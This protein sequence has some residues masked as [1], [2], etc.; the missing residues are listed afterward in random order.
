MVIKMKILRA[1]Q[2]FLIILLVQSIVSS[3]AVDSSY[4]C[5]DE[6]CME[7]TEIKFSVNIFNNI[8]KTIIVKD[9]YI[10][11]K[12]YGTVLAYDVS[13]DVFLKPNEAHQ[14]NF[15][16]LVKAPTKGYTFYYVPCFTVSHEE[17]PEEESE[18]CG[19]IVKSITVIPLDKIECRSDDECADDEYCNTFSLYRCEKLECGEDETIVN[20]KCV[21]VMPQQITVINWWNVFVFFLALIVAIFFMFFLFGRKEQKDEIDEDFDIDLSDE[22]NKDSA[23]EEKKEENRKQESKKTEKKNKAEKEFKEENKEE[24]N[25]DENKEKMPKKKNKTKKKYK[26]VK[27]NIKP[28]IDENAYNSVDEKSE[29]L[30]KHNPGEAPYDEDSNSGVVDYGGYEDDDE[31]N[32]DPFN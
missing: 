12:D 11:D 20:H 26:R 17:T 14:F 7:G 18:I 1:I 10:R 25:P 6:N 13:K 28:I 24:E 31:E 23:Q 27:N 9:V 21:K 16:N 19:K 5:E 22:N 29:D 8:N 2:V 30:K 4:R 3:A 32:R 15:T